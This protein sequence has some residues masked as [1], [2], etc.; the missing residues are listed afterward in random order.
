[1]ALRLWNTNTCG[2]HQI[3]WQVRKGMVAMVLKAHKLNS[4]D[5]GK[6]ILGILCLQSR[7]YDDRIPSY[8]LAL[9]PV[10]K[11]II[12][13]WNWHVKSVINTGTVLNLTLGAWMSY[14]VLVLTGCWHVEVVNHPLAGRCICFYDYGFEQLRTGSLIWYVVMLNPPPSHA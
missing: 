11:R 9:N 4:F 12:K 6:S 7:L 14:D 8:R 5:F 10:I 2:I 3:H 1:V 13:R